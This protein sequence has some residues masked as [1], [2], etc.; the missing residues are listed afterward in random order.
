[1]ALKV[2]VDP[3]R[4]ATQGWTPERFAENAANRG[5]VVGADGTGNPLATDQT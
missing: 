2:V 4:I 1:M 5:A 3:A